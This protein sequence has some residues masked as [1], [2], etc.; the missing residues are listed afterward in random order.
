MHWRD[1]MLEFV[2][3]HGGRGQTI[4]SDKKLALVELIPH[5]TIAA[6]RS[7]HLNKSIVL[8]HALGGRNGT[9]IAAGVAGRRSCILSHYWAPGCR[10]R[11]AP[12]PAASPPLPYLPTD[13]NPR[14]GRVESRVPDDDG[15]VVLCRQAR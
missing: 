12:S 4:C 7:L 2:F 9:P 5:F 15:G 3:Y 13:R 6:M 10:P 11:A 14:E 1:K 8:S